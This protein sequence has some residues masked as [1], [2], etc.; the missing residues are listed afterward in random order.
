MAAIKDRLYFIYR[1]NNGVDYLCPLNTAGKSHAV[2][3]DT[4]D[5]CVEKE[6]VERYSGNINIESE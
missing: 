4:L 5:D 3:D 1:H 6:V 2:S